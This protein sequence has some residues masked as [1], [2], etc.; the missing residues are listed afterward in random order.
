MPLPTLRAAAQWYIALGLT[1]I[2]LHGKDAWAKE[3]NTR[4]WSV[5]DFDHPP[6]WADNIGL[7]I[8]NRMFV[9]DVD[10]K[11]GRNGPDDLRQLIAAN[12]PLPR[13][14]TARTGSGGYHLWF[15][16][17]SRVGNGRGKL[18]PSIDVRGSGAGQVAVWPSIHPSTGRAYQWL[19]APDAM[20]IA[21]AP[22]W[23]LALLTRPEPPSCIPRPPLR[24]TN[25]SRYGLAA[26]KRITEEL[27]TLPCG[28]RNESMNQAAYALGQL[29]GGNE[30]R[31]TTAL[32]ALYAIAEA[33]GQDIAKSKSTIDRAFNA[34]RAVPRSTF[35]K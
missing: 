2:P 20:P 35:T 8:R 4:T 19:V 9:L 26:V 3:W 1:P 16:A 30:L 24:Y 33:W 11:P 10:N 22:P 25:G 28:S 23:L 12:G 27:A 29:V 17:T 34:G 18:P 14:W 21:D 15:A 6:P 32:D 31:D 7:S 5:A 13:T